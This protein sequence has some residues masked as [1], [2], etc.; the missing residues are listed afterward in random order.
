MEIATAITMI[1]SVPGAHPD[2]DHRAEGNFGKG[3]EDHQI[4]FQDFGNQ[5]RLP[6]QDRQQ[7][8]SERTDDKP[9][10]GLIE[11]NGKMH[12]DLIVAQGEEG[13]Q[14]PGGTA[15]DKAVD[16]AQPGSDFPQQQ[17]SHQD[18]CPPEG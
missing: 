6:E 4:G 11:R 7:Q 10:E 14:N 17:K 5:F 8:A 3:I 2:D 13:I 12:E 9:G 18:A 15:H 1:A 16:P